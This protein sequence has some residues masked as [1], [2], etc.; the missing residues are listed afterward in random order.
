MER[1]LFPCCGEVTGGHSR[2][3]RPLVDSLAWYASIHHMK[4]L[5]LREKWEGEALALVGSGEETCHFIPLLCGLGSL[6]L[7]LSFLICET[8][9]I[10][11]T[12]EGR[13][14]HSK[15]ELTLY[16]TFNYLRLYLTL[17]PDCELLEDGSCLSTVG[18]GWGTKD[19]YLFRAQTLSAWLRKHT[20]SS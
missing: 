9:M 18:R 14:E 7:N 3:T 13:C 4:K 10:T 8:R 15:C 1:A 11:L 2:N 12:S 17:L 6:S 5:R 16:L 20:Q 19:Y